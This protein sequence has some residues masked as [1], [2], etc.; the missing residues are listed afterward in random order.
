MNEDSGNVCRVYHTSTQTFKYN[1]MQSLDSIK[2]TCINS[3]RRIFNIYIYIYI[4]RSISQCDVDQNE[5][6]HADQFTFLCRFNLI[7]IYRS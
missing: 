2:N 3:H 1:R 6:I 7:Y 4:Y 5:D